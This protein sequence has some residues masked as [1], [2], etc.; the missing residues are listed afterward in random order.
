MPALQRRKEKMVFLSQS[1]GI[2]YWANQFYEEEN[3]DF[4]F[5]NDGT[6]IYS[7]NAFS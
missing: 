4:Y 3:S 1:T 7:T 6:Y 2:W 5:V